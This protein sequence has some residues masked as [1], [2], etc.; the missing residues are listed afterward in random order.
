MAKTGLID[1]IDELLLDERTLAAAIANSRHAKVQEVT[2]TELTATLGQLRNTGDIDQIL[3]IERSLLQNDLDH[4]KTSRAMISSLQKA[5]T[6]HQATTKLVAFVRDPAAYQAINDGYTLPKNLLGNVPHDEARQYFR[7]HVTRITN[8]DSAR[9]DQ[10]EKSVLDE[11]RSN[12]RVAERI[13]TQLQRE[14]LG[15]SQK[16]SENE[17][18]SQRV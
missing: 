18:L 1:K 2:R 4:Y 9:L 16:Q 3:D 6:E 5:L 8:W 14:A 15:L 17:G 12:I 13:Y 7:S 10:A 11:R